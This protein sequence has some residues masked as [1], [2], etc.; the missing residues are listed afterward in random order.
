MPN[1]TAEE[2]ALI[3]E[4]DGAMETIGGINWERMPLET[5]YLRGYQFPINGISALP[6]GYPAATF[7]PL[8]DLELSKALPEE[9]ETIEKWAE[10]GFRDA[11]AS[12][13]YA[14]ALRYG[15]I[16]NLN[17]RVQA[18]EN[19]QSQASKASSRPLQTAR[20]FVLQQR[21]RFPEIPTEIRTILH[22]LH[23]GTNAMETV[24]RAALGI[25]PHPESHAGFIPT[26]PLYAVAALPFDPKKGRKEVRHVPAMAIKVHAMMCAR[27]SFVAANSNGMESLTAHVRARRRAS[28]T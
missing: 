14:W 10:I 8:R 15:L 27:L 1:F 4:Y 22:N 26:I 23:F 25:A 7:P 9:C 28:A 18:I 5:I 11:M 20:L 16:Q 21:E 24:C 13:N 12:S 2:T 6:P 19:S 3:E 17:L